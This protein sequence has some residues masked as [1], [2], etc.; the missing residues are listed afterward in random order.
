MKK[1]ILLCV[2]L[3]AGIATR[4]PAQSK[5]SA[6]LPVK[7]GN[8]WQMPKDVL[9]RSRN[10]SNHCQKLLSL[11]SATTQKLFQLYLGNTKSVDEIRIG[12]APEKEK[13]AALAANQQQFDAR[14]RPLLTAAQWERYTQERKAGK[15]L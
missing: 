8:E 10:F 11:D 12:N 1:I 5:D 13:K 7:T 14:V 2:V 15:L 4:L 3:G 6:S 9:V